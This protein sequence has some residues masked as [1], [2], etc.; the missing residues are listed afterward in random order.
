MKRPMILLSAAL[1]AGAMAAPA[2]AQEN[3]NTPYGRHHQYAERFD[4]YL[5]AHPDVSQ[6]LHKNPRLI[7][8]P[9]FVAN[10]PDFHEY[11][12]KHPRVREALRRHPDRFMRR[13]RRYDISENHWKRRHDHDADAH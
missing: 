1:L 8:N 11:L 12:E 2:L 5:D 7:D 13:E 10:H 3:P 4:S 9:Q 6:A